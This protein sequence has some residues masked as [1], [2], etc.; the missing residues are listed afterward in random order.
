MI[1]EVT[2]E[3]SFD[4]AHYLIGYR[5]KCAN[6]HGHH[7]VLQVTLR[8]K[9][10]DNQGMILDFG[11]IKEIVN[12]LIINRLDHKCIN[13]IVDFNPTAENLAEW[14]FNQLFTVFNGLYKDVSLNSVKLWE[15]PG[16]MTE[17][18]RE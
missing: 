15:S 2:K 11:E 5:G 6:N 13:D 14:I 1:R 4:S 12:R 18:R 8:G 3:F 9:S 10:L 16:N 7:F 17:Y